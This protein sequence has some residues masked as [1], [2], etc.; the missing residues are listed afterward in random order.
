MK[1]LNYNFKKA[2]K[3]RLLQMSELEEIRESAYENSRIYKECKNRWHDAKVKVKKFKK[4]D[5]MLLFYSR[6][7]LFSGKLKSRWSGPFT[8][9]NSYPH[10][11]MELCNIRVD[12]FK[13]NE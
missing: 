12:T 1:A 11:A 2:A 7:R 9:T 10:G 4:G 5:Q 3:K 13:V 6:L 8:M